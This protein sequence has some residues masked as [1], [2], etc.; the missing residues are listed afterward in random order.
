MKV[1][2]KHI[3]E[4]IVHQDQGN[5][6]LILIQRRKPGMVDVEDHLTRLVVLAE[7]IIKVPRVLIH[8]LQM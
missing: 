2:I 8:I 4:A 3:Q 5:C 1:H 6:I 7:K